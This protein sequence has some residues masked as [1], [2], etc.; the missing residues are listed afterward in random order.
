MKKYVTFTKGYFRATQGIGIEPRAYEA[1][2]HARKLRKEN[3]K[4]PPLR[5]TPKLQA[6]IARIVEDF[7]EN[8]IE[9]ILGYNPLNGKILPNSTKVNN[10]WI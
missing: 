10:K 4:I 2:Q 6:E 1:I 3:S 7:Y 8:E 9:P 5:L